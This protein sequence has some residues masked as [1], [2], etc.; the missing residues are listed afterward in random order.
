MPFPLRWLRKKRFQIPSALAIALAGYLGYAYHEPLIVPLEPDRVWGLNCL[1]AEDLVIQGHDARGDVWATR[2]LLAYRCRKGEKQFVRQFRVPTG[3]SR[4]WLMNLSFVRRLTHRSECVE[5]LS[6]PGGAACAM[7]GGYMWY[8]PSEG[9]PF[10]KTLALDNFGIGVGRGI[11][12]A[13]LT[14]SGNKT[15]LFGEYFR[16]DAHTR[17]RIYVSKN[18]GQTWKIA[19][20]FQPGRIRH[21]HSVQKDLFTDKVWVCTGD[22]DDEPMIAWTTDAGQTLHPIGQGGQMWRTCQLVFTKDAV[23][24]GSDTSQEAMRGVYRWN[25]KT[26]EVAKLGEVSNFILFGTRL[27]DGTVVMS[28]DIE[29]HEPGLNEK[30]KLWVVSDG[31]TVR[32]IPCGS[33]ARYRTFSSSIAAY[34]RMAYLRFQRTQGSDDLHLTCQNTEGCDGDL[35]VIGAEE[36]RKASAS[37]RPSSVRSIPSNGS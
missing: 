4:Y 22:E 28:S 34:L 33:R 9:A 20:E 36:L 5:L 14:L 37:T 12:P 10:E 19:H 29:S 32:M 7:A 2:G 23:L 24:W 1:R 3:W 35:L 8:R 13:G 25:R 15:I 11:S 26:E 30:T 16:N 17:V 31:K 21:V 18:D 6:L 27:A